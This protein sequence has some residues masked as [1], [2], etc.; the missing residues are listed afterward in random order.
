MGIGTVDVKM[1]AFFRG[2]ITKSYYARFSKTTLKFLFAVFRE[3]PPF[4][5]RPL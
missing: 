1:K 2:K 4:S 3:A 5:F